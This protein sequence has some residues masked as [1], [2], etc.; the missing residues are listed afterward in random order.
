MKTSPRTSRIFG[1][2]PF[3]RAGTE[4]MVRM[5]LRNVVTDRAV[6]ARGRVTQ[7]SVLIQERNGDAVDLR[8]DHDGNLL[9][10]Q[11]PLQSAVEIGHLFFRIGVV[12]TEHRYAMSDLGECFL[13]RTADALGRRIREA[14]WGNS[15]PGRAAR[16]RACRI[17]D[18]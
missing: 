16:D 1:A 3:N 7:L 14:N 11:K 8:L 4:R 5:F 15:S 13:R 6:A 9:V 17:R 10:R 12:E 2:A 18:R